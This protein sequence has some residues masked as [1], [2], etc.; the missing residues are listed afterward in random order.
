MKLGLKLILFVV[1]Q[2]ANAFDEEPLPT[3]ALPIEVISEKII[4]QETLAPEVPIEV[5]EITEVFEDIDG[6][7]EKG[8]LPAE[9]PE[10]VIDEEVVTEVAITSTCNAMAPVDPINQNGTLESSET[11]VKLYLL[12]CP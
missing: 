1:C 12:W 2:M 6:V 7:L 10:K 9:V 3:F 4:E 5:I 11:P 8:S